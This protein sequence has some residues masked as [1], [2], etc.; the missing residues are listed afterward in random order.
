MRIS[1]PRN[2]TIFLIKFHRTA[3]VTYQFGISEPIDTT[4][5]YEKGESFTI[6]ELD[7]LCLE[8]PV[9]NLLCRKV[10]YMGRSIDL[11]VT[12]E[13]MTDMWK[14]NAGR[15][16]ELFMN[17]K[18]R[19]IQIFSIIKTGFLIRILEKP[20]SFTTILH[21]KTL[22]EILFLFFT[23]FHKKT[24]GIHQLLI[25]YLINNGKY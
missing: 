23:L 5:N 11:L 17:N 15:D 8:D 20:T 6:R 18:V 22:N 2:L 13:R 25:N 7:D 12:L 9:I 3:D 21:L 4:D 1:L 16:C 24:N 14:M 19:K 10:K